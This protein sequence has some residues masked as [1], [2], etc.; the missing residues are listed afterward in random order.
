MASSGEGIAAASTKGKHILVVDDEE[1]I[2]YVIRSYLEREHLNVL[3][4]SSPKQAL[5][6][7]QDCKDCSLVLSDI[8]MPEMNGFEFVR[9]VRKLKPEIKILFMTAFEIN[10]SEF[11]QVLPST[12]IEGFIKK[13]AGQQEIVERVMKSLGTETELSG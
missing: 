4:F 10:Q 1:D 7:L 13:P 2:L 12:K 8:R 11:E 3:T 6:H 5:E 9:N